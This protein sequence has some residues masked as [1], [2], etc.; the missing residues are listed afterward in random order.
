MTLPE[1][2]CLADEAL[3]AGD[4]GQGHILGQRYKDHKMLVAA[5]TLFN[6]MGRALLLSS[7]K[8]A[9]EMCVN[10]GGQGQSQACS[11][12]QSRGTPG[13][14]GVSPE[15]QQPNPGAFTDARLYVASP[16]SACAAQLGH[17]SRRD[18]HA[19]CLQHS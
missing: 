8:C 7:L 14:R 13:H 17:I 11:E 4:Q 16:A 10:T 19:A 9:A 5:I 6:M 1:L 2:M 3:T 12:G 15:A 18:E